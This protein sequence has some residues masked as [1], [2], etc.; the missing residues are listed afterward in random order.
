[1]IS[2][3]R[4]VKR[5]VFNAVSSNGRPKAMSPMSWD[6]ATQALP[7]MADEGPQGASMSQDFV[8]HKV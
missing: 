4:L 1:M 3:I 5:R 8:Y 7:G 6:D 2:G